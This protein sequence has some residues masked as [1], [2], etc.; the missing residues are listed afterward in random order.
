[1]KRSTRGALVAAVALG[2]AVAGTLPA[3][4]HDKPVV[5]IEKD[6]SFD[7]VVSPGEGCSFTT[8]IHG[9]AD[10]KT[11][12]TRRTTTATYTHATAR[13][14]N[15][16]N[17]KSVT[18]NANVTFVDKELANGDLASSLK[19]NAILWGRHVGFSAGSGPA[20]IYIRGKASW[21]TVSDGSDD[22]PAVFHKIKGQ[23]TNVCD[24]VD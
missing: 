11:V 15:P 23:V 19:G 9:E 24:L 20:F 4:A 2:T 5:T 7:A 17:K 16:A 10:I 12:T 8:T 22:A 18:L 14:T 1:M 6:T 13:I 3:T 21:T